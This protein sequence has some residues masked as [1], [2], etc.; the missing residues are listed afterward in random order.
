MRPKTTAP[1][2]AKKLVEAHALAQAGASIPLILR[3]S[4]FGKR[5]VRDLVKSHGQAPAR[6]RR[7]PRR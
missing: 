3:L 2:T 1:D 6:K 7:D 4:G 5:F